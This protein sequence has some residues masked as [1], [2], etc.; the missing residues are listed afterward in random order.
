MKTKNG[1][2]N[3]LDESEYKIEI[4]NFIFYFS[5]KMYLEK[6]IKGKEE[7]IKEESL[8]I[9]NKYNVES[10][11]NIMLLLSLYKKIEKRGFKIFDK[12]LNREIKEKEVIRDM[13]IK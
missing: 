2:Y 13:L 8:K 3:N 6:F 5:S 1:I 10:R 12:V 4:E 9:N 7:Y 11:F